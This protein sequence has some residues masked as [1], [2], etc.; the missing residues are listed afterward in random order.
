MADTLQVC[1]QGTEAGYLS[2]ENRQ[3]LFS[4]MPET[5]VS[6]FVPLTPKPSSRL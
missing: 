6:H 2:H 3:H 5:P 1:V 4:Y